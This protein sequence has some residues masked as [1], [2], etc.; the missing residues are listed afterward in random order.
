MRTNSQRPVGWLVLM[1]GV[2][3]LV[4]GTGCAATLIAHTG[5]EEPAL[6]LPEQRAEVKE[7]FGQPEKT[8]TLPDGLTIDTYRLRKKLETGS[9]ISPGANPRDG[10]DA[11]QLFCYWAMLNLVTF[12]APEALA[13]GVVLYESIHDGYHIAF[14]YDQEDQIVLRYLLNKPPAERFLEVQHQLN[15]RLWDA[16]ENTPAPLAPSIDAHGTNLRRWAHQV[17]YSLPPGAEEFLQTALLLARDAD[18]GRLSREETLIWLR[19][20][21]SYNPFAC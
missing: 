11:V 14:V 16:L 9:L 8:E 19:S 2:T 13:G 4:S 18:E 21:N 3:I 6:Y 12:G 20:C 10:R 7:R 1:I 5:T 15:H 17:D